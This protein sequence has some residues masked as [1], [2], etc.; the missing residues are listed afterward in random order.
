MVQGNGVLGTVFFK[1]EFP[2]IFFQERVNE[3]EKIFQDTNIYYKDPE[4]DTE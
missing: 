2:F 3:I 1:H 4:E